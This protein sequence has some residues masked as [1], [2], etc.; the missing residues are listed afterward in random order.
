[1]ICRHKASMVVKGLMQGRVE[2]T[3]SPAVDFNTIRTARTAAVW[4]NMIIHHMGVKTAFLHGEIEEERYVSSSDG[5]SICGDRETPKLQ[6][7]LNSLKQPP[8]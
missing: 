5:L 4:K 3:F 8:K 7:G 2:E 6:K 1:M